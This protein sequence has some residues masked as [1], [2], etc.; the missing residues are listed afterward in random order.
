MSYMSNDSQV[1]ERELEAQEVFV[2]ADLTAA[3]SDMPSN[4]TIDNSTL[5]ATVITLDANQAVSKAFMVEVRNRAT[6]AIVAIAAAPVVSDQTIAVTCNGTGITSACI[7]F[8][9]KIA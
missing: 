7:H 3:T 1:Q 5:T 2:V 8:V 6:G 9:Y 4:V